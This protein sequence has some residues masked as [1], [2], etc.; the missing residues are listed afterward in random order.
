IAQPLGFNMHAMVAAYKNRIITPPEDRAKLGALPKSLE[1]IDGV[2]LY[3][4]SPIDP[5]EY[6]LTMEQAMQSLSLLE[7]TSIILGFFGH[8][9]V[10]AFYEFDI[11][12][13]QFYDVEMNSDVP[14]EVNLDGSRRY[15]INPGSVGQPRDGDPKASFIIFNMDG[16]RGSVLLHRVSYPIKECQAKMRRGDFPD[17]LVKRLDLGF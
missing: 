10:P 16:K 8:T 1:V 3:H 15:L 12:A 11:R 14:L 2:G 13:G 6:L 9:H 7:K 5:D 4:G 17:I